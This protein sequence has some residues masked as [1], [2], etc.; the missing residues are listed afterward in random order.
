MMCNFKWIWLPN[1]LRASRQVQII[2]NVGG[3]DSCFVQSWQT[4]LPQGDVRRTVC[5]YWLPILNWK[6]SLQFYLNFFLR[7]CWNVLI[8]VSTDL[9]THGASICTITSSIY[10]AFLFD[11]IL[12]INMSFYL[13]VPWVSSYLALLLSA[14]DL[15][16]VWGISIDT[17][18]LILA[19]LVFS[20]FLQW[21]LKCWLPN[22]CDK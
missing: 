9:Y 18:Y 19:Y 5:I 11:I 4:V 21:T 2:V 22:I 7:F 15:H 16:T 14:F 17:S 20:Y 3:E 8:F 10:I 13:F 6:R 1:G 12:F